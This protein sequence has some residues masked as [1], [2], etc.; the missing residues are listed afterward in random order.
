MK[1]LFVGSHPN[2]VKF[3]DLDGR[4]RVC[5]IRAMI[6]DAYRMLR[7]S[8]G[9][10]AKNETNTFH[11]PW[12]VFRNLMNDHPAACLEE[13]RH[14]SI[15]FDAD[16]E[17]KV[18]EIADLIEQHIE[19]T[20]QSL[21]LR[22]THKHQADVMVGIARTDD[23]MREV[24]LMRGLGK[25]RGDA[26]LET[27]LQHNPHRALADDLRKYLDHFKER[28]GIFELCTLLTKRYGKPSFDTYADSTVDEMIDETCQ[29]VQSVN[30]P[31]DQVYDLV[32]R[33]ILSFG[34]PALP[35]DADD[36]D[37]QAADDENYALAP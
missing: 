26:V 5:E 1:Q 27:E 2:T 15:Y 34:L 28:D 11:G 7:D 22:G 23:S 32:C 3:S 6:T 13:F 33:A 20:R 10:Q 16:T 4:D 24:T 9:E 18:T 12:L 8:I 21:D 17:G 29:A 35:A 25:S 36:K 37:D 19:L 31:I 30:E 14:A